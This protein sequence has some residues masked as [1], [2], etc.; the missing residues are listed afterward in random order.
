MGFMVDIST[1]IARPSGG[2][3]GRP[4]P[5]RHPEEHAA[6]KKGEGRNSKNKRH[7]FHK[8]QTRADHDKPLSQADRTDYSQNNGHENSA[9]N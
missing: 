2:G 1:M 6:R 3:A 8:H 9:G 5:V 7:R 4:K